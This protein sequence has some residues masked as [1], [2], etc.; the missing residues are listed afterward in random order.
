MDLEKKGM[1]WGRSYEK[2]HR[3]SNWR[4]KLAW[5]PVAVEEVVGGG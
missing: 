3:Q 2:I 1:T 5:K 4:E